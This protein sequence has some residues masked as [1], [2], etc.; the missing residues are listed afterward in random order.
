MSTTT[1]KNTVL[2][3]VDMR[4]LEEDGQSMVILYLV[5]YYFCILFISC[6]YHNSC[7]RVVLAIL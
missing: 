4:L 5:I 6:C 2:R 7:I 3:V 1:N